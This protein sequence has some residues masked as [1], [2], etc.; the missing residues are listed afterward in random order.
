MI[1]RRILLLL[2]AACVVGS[3]TFTSGAA[4][5]K[6]TTP[7]RTAPKR[8]APSGPRL[9]PVAETRLLMEGL[10]LPNLR[11][12]EKILKENP[13]DNEAWSYARGQAL[14]IAETGNLLMIRPPHNKGEDLW[15]ERAQSLRSAAARLAR[16][17]AKRD[18]PAGRKALTA[19]ALRCNACHESF[20]VEARIT[21]FEKDEKDEKD[22]K[23]DQGNEQP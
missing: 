1:S 10:N 21:P 3:T 14:L 17:L 16:T 23:G 15:L 5:K 13:R 7:K 8:A 9:L 2:A 12:L 18:F 4:P 19:L 6:R 22:E 20:R 11:G